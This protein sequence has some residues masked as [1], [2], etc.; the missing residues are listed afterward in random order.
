[1][2]DLFGKPEDRFS[3]VAAQIILIMQVAFVLNTRCLLV[4]IGICNS[5]LKIFPMRATYR[6]LTFSSFLFQFKYWKAFLFWGMVLN[7]L[8][9]WCELCILN[10]FV[11]PH[12]FGNP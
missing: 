3:R 6:L 5:C 2:S 12:V 9:K 4:V 7:F 10:N 8:Q 1:M 11:G